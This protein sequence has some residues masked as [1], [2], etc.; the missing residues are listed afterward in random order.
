MKSNLILTILLFHGVLA[1]AQPFQ[2]IFASDSTRW[3]VFEIIPDAGLNISY[4]SY[5]DTLIDEKNYHILYRSEFYTEALYPVYDLR[6][7]GYIHED[8][9]SGKYWFLKKI[10][11][12]WKEV[13]FM[14]LGL[15]KGDTM[16]VV[17]DF[18]FMNTDSVLVDSVYYEDG[19]KIIAID[20][21]HFEFEG[22][23]R[24]K[25]MEGIGASNGFYMAEYYEQASEFTL[26]CKFDN[27]I[28]TYQNTGEHYNACYV[29]PG[30]NIHNTPMKDPF[31]VYPNPSEG[32]ISIDTEDFLQGNA[33]TYAIY[34][35]T[36][37]LLLTGRISDSHTEL[38]LKN[39]G[40][41][42]I[43]FFSEDFQTTRRILIY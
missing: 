7:C 18:R 41:F 8:T 30:G 16:P 35:M 5:S 10:D 21:E 27:G 26:I 25:Y 13:L 38:E 3:N 34:N 17:E 23:A 12:E 39:K 31:L 42:L 2:S 9:V 36:G 40:L 28:K 1:M 6:V 43:H 4:F 32:R 29:T 20:R 22:D 19:R 33:Y 37:G 14:D 15:E 11:S 24:I